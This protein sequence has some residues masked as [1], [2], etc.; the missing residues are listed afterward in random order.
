MTTP[1]LPTMRRYRCGVSIGRAGSKARTPSRNVIRAASGVMIPGGSF[2]P[3]SLSEATARSA[4]RIRS[5]AIMGHTPRTCEINAD[6]APARAIKG[7]VR[8]PPMPVL[9]SAPRSCCRSKPIKAPAARATRK[10]R[11]DSSIVIMVTFY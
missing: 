5:V 3:H 9:R 10:P 2:R 4:P 8:T 6:M 1:A 11:M 7:K